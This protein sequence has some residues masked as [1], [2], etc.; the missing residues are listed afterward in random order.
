L[1]KAG[2]KR[3]IKLKTEKQMSASAT[4]GGAE[5]ECDVGGEV[6]IAAAATLKAVNA[7]MNVEANA[8]ASATVGDVG[9]VG[10]VGIAADATP[11]TMKASM[12]VEAHASATGTVGPLGVKLNVASAT[13][14]A[15]GVDIKA[16]NL[17]VKRGKAEAAATAKGPDV[18]FSDSG[19]QVTVKAEAKA[20][21]VG[22]EVNAASVRV[23]SDRVS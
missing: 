22:V 19:L 15:K 8:S 12:N 20:K 4:V 17:D 11:N 14:T 3:Q 2:L 18:T 10:E 5:L 9:L 21:V 16:R 6:W 7:S 1:K 13:A 23:V